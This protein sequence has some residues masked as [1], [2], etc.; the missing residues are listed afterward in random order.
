VA[1]V[2][3]L[4][5]PSIGTAAPT[6]TGNVDLDFDGP[7]D[8][9]FADPAG[10]DVGVPIALNGAISGHDIEDVR[11]SYDALDD[12]LY[13][14]IRTFGI[15]TD[16][17]GDGDEGS[18]SAALAALGGVDEPLI[19]GTESFAFFADLDE[20]GVL[21]VIAG[22]P[23]GADASGY[24]VSSFLGT[25]VAPGVSFGP[26]LDA[27]HQGEFFG[28]PT[29][30]EPH[31]EFAI[32]AFSQ[33]PTST[34]APVGTDFSIG[35]FV[36]SLSDAGIGED[37]FPGVFQ[38]TPVDVGSC[39]DGIVDPGEQCDDGNTLDGDGCS[40]TCETEGGFV[41]ECAGGEA[42]DLQLEGASDLIGGTT[43]AFR[44]VFECPDGEVLY[45]VSGTF[46]DN[47]PGVLVSMDLLCAVPAVDPDTGAVVL[48]PQGAVPGVRAD[49][50]QVD[51]P[52]STY[53]LTCGMDEV[54]V[55]FTGE[56]GIAAPFNP[57]RTTGVSELE[58]QCAGLEVLDGR[59]SIVGNTKV[60]PPV[61]QGNPL[62]GDTDVSCALDQLGT[63]VGGWGRNYLDGARLVCSSATAGCGGEPSVCRPFE[64]CGDGVA[65]GLEA[66]DDGNNVSGDGCSATCQVEVCGDGI[67]QEGEACDDGNAVD[68][69]GC[70]STCDTECPP[71]A[72]FDMQTVDPGRAIWFSDLDGDGS[73]DRYTISNT[74]FDFDIE[75]GIAT[76]SG[77]AAD[78]QDA[79]DTWTFTFSFAYR[80]QGDDGAGS[81]SPYLDVASP[82]QDQIDA[83]L[84]FDLIAG[85]MISTSDGSRVEASPR[86]ADGS[87]PMQLGFG[88][89]GFT[90]DY[91]FAVWFGGALYDVDGDFVRT[92]NGDINTELD[93]LDP[94][95]PT[96]PPCTGPEC[97][98]VEICDGVDNDFDGLVD[99]GL[100]DCEET[101]P[102]VG[103]FDM[104]SVDPGRAIW[105]SDLDGDGS[106]DRY[107][108]TGTVFDFDIDTGIATYSGTASHMQDP[109]DTWTFTYSFA[110]RGQ[111]A[112]GEGSA[113]PYLYLASPTQEQIDDWLYFDLIAGELLNV[114]DGS[115]VEVSPRP[116]DGSK[117][118]QL[119]FGANG[120]NLE[121]GFA[122]WFG[123]NLFDG[124]GNFVRQVEGDI[125]TEL[126]ELDD[127]C[128]TAPPC[129]T[130]E[131]VPLEICDGV[132]NDF[133]GEVDEGF[134][135]SSVFT[136]TET[137][138]GSGG[139]ITHNEAV[140]D[141][142]TGL[143]TYDI[144]IDHDGSHKA[145]GFTVALNDGPNPKG[146]AELALL[147]FD[148]TGTSPVL[149]AYAYNGLNTRTSY[150]DGS[151]ASGT[152]APD[153]ILSANDQP[154]WVLDIRATDTGSAMVFSFT[155]DTVPIRLHQP[156][157]NGSTW[158]W[159][160]IGFDELAG[161]W[162]HTYKNLH[163]A[164]DAHG[165]LTDYSGNGFGFIDSADRATTSEEV[166]YPTG[167][168]LD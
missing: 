125:N 47:C 123:G 87:K 58:I 22:V 36:G 24:R 81:A 70:S 28:A 134:A 7:N 93:E 161:Q 127:T 27:I 60:G 12:T 11:L 136:Y 69:D 20:D 82:T 167:A 144:T 147:F 103:A 160:G 113:S 78:T 38:F 6:F 8:L 39:G 3:A 71:V 122:V 105:F 145:E 99:E 159:Y 142:G 168:P 31:L 42:F 74:I 100:P 157:Y 19:G 30:T 102:P 64:D 109:S 128:P 51:L 156:L 140:Y 18:T 133:D 16:A 53:S 119:G 163:T 138:S 57:I 115:R 132:D 95:C 158:P 62:P 148:A 164:Y 129:T 17:D 41:C 5:L 15:A 75:T 137:S 97:V 50:S 9:V 141:T 56:S 33:L 149:T 46:V 35:L 1:C 114:A 96:A 117:P 101:C 152:Q 106:S 94:T 135:T 52:Q 66:C 85:E 34:G 124:A 55:G 151:S 48:S 26:P 40:S 65:E 84:Y 49:G 29:P 146:H 107:S 86:P 166:C 80:G 21:D 88:A 44:G 14:G 131:C 23:A 73:S 112:E 13:I 139:R 10:L 54:V 98:P 143:L 150:F 32:T 111:G 110:Y 130:P 90:P 120:F 92:I 2:V 43:S 79:N 91:G 68:G 76:Y 121:Y 61:A 67:V 165:W 153:R 154:F 104:T 59:V 37:F 126:Q 108:I 155:I 83:W 118:M 89:N 63:G 116:A 45:G 4:V 25:P 162:L 72:A 77:M